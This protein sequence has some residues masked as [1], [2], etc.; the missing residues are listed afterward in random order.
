M[1]TEDQMLA[2]KDEMI[3][4]RRHLHEHPELGLEEYKTSAFVASRLAE[5][6]WS[7]TTGV[8]QTG[9]VG[10]LSKGTGRRAIGIRADFDALPID[11]ETNLP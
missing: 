10:T 9:V 7:V 11:E 6:G 5:W 8:G 1:R 3:A 4:I 2:M